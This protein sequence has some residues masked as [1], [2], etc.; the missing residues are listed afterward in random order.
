M[1]NRGKRH[2]GKIQREEKERERKKKRWLER[3]DKIRRGKKIIKDQL[4]MI[5]SAR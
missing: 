3:E 1:K 4:Q 5:K 2:V